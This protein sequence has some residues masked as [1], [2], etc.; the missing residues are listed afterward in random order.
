MRE[1]EGGQG[2]EEK[3]REEVNERKEWNLMHRTL[4]NSL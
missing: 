2:R 3:E 4:L 1:G